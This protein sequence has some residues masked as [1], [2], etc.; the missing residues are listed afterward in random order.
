MH[1]QEKN[2]RLRYGRMQAALL[3]A[4]IAGM[5]QSQVD[6]AF[7]VIRD[8]LAAVVGLNRKMSEWI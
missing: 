1:S 8:E 4:L 5:P 3:D 2:G 6:D 7:S